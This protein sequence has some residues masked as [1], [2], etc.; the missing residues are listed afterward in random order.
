MGEGHRVLGDYRGGSD[1]RLGSLVKH[2]EFEYTGVVTKQDKSS[3]NGDRWLVQW[4]D[5]VRLWWCSACELE[6]ICK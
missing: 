5:H 1:M 4:C 3:F 2:I 6:V